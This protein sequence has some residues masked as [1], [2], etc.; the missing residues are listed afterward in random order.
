MWS[1]IVPAK[2]SAASH[3]KAFIGRQRAVLHNRRTLLDMDQCLA[4]LSV[5]QRYTRVVIVERDHLMMP[6][7]LH[8]H[9]NAPG[10]VA[11]F[12]MA[13]VVAHPDLFTGI[14][15]RHRVSTAAP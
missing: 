7:C 15:P 5:P 8:M 1:A 14:L 2:S 3:S 13:A 12:D 4:V 11:H 10:A 9:R 6:H